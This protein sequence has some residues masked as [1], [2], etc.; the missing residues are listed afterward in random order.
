MSIRE[1]VVAVLTIFISMWGSVFAYN[2]FIGD[3]KSYELKQEIT[4][5][6]DESMGKLREDINKLPTNTDVENSQLKS[7]LYAKDLLDEKK[8]DEV[9][10][11]NQLELQLEH[12]SRKLDV[13]RQRPGEVV[14]EK[15]YLAN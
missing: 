14:P 11:L 6:F 3:Q 13:Q 9:R 10:R 2:E 1:N 12:L 4:G 5:H 7:M 15:E 8:A